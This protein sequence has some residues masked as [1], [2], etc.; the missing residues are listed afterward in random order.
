[1]YRPDG[2]NVKCATVPA[3]TASAAEAVRIAKSI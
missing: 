1:M 3:K 2:A